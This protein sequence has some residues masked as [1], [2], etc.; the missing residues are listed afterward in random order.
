ME[1]ETLYAKSKWATTLGV[2]TSGYY[3]W[4]KEREFRVERKDQLRPDVLRVF[5]QGRGSYGAEKICCILRT[6]G[7]KAS[8]GVVSTIMREEGISS[9][10]MKR[11]QRSLTDSTAARDESYQNLVKDLEITGPF[12]VLSSDIT[13]IP[14][15]QGFD[16]HVQVMDVYTK[17]VLGSAQKPHMKAELV[18]EAIERAIDRYHLSEGI[19]FHSD[20]G[21]QYTSR[22]VKET[23]ESLG[24]KASYS[25]V[26]KPGDNA[27][28]ESFFALLK[29]EVVHGANFKTREE[30]HQSVFEYIYDF[31]NPSRKQ[32]ALGHLSPNEFALSLQEQALEKVA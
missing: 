25:R 14:T 29:K 27:W 3:T 16:Y 23:L 8:F 31:Y 12:Q 15:A 30:A 17:Q 32:K 2:S 22:L 28:S 21:S 9:K 5:A 24:W 1:E 6:E 11:R 7:K 19:Y 18:T 20:R 26:G 10:H 13:Y 4:L